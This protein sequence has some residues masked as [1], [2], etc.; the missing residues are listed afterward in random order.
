MRRFAIIITTVALLLNTCITGTYAATTESGTPTS[1]KVMFYVKPDIAVE[2]DGVRQVLKDAD[3]QSVYPIVYNGTAYLPVRAISA[4]LGEPVEWDSGSKT[5]YIGKTLAYPMKASAPIPTAAAIA[6]NSSDVAEMNRIEPSL[7]TGYSKSDIFVMYDFVIQAFKDTNNI[8]VYPLNYNGTTYLP[9]ES[10]SSLMDETITWD[11]TAKK[12]SI[13][14]GKISG[15]ET[16]VIDAT[17]ALFKDL[18]EREEALYYEASAKIASVKNATAEEKQAIATSASDNYL[19]AQAITLEVKAV[20]QTSFTEE[21]KTTYDKML[22]F[23]ESNE[24]YIL[25]LENVAYLAASD[26]D[27]SMLADTFLYFAVDAQTKMEAARTLIIQ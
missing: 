11:G 20:K 10:L 19:K 17:A 2:L 8:T 16:E 15:E 6:A 13:S 14:I 9:I 27:Y 18:Y 4:L 24:Y 22:A 26:S 3:E 1:K 12:I 7:V 25:V 5:I 21:E 23:A